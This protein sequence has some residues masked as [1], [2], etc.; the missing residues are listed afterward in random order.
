GHS[1]TALGLIAASYSAGFMMGAMIATQLLARVGHIRVYAASAAIFAAAT[2]A[3]HFSGEIWAWGVARMIAGMAVALMFAAIE[4]WLSFSIS[5][6]VRGE[7]LSVYMV[8]TKG[9]LALGPFLAFD[10]APPEAEPWM[11]AVG[12]AELS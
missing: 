12:L 8:L 7:V 2:L 10:Y 5:A 1:R 9:A 11:Y 4:S 6:R 3:L